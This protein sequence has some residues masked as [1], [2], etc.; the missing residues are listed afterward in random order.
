VDMGQR[1]PWWVVVGMGVVSKSMGGQGGGMVAR[2]SVGVAW[3]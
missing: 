1:W 3:W 2:M